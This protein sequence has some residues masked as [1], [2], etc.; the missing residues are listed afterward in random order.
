MVIIKSRPSSRSSDI[1][2]LRLLLGL[3]AA[4]LFVGPLRVHAAPELLFRVT[5]DDLTANA[6]V[7][8]GSPTSALARDLGLTAKEGFNKKSALLLG[9]GEECGY[10]VKDNLNLAA[11]TISFWAKPHNWDDTENRFQK[12]FWVHGFEGGVPFGIYIDSPNSGSAARVVLSYRRQG[13]PGSK[14]YQLNGKADWRSGKWH[15]IDMTWDARHLA[16]YVNG[17]LG[18]RSEITDVTFP[19]FDGKMFRLVPI[20]HSGDGAYH[21]GKDRSLIDDFEIWSGPLSADRILQRYM[22]DI[23]GEIPPPMVVVPRAGTAVTLDGKLD[24]G[25]WASASC[26]PIPIN[27]ATMYPHTRW[28]SASICYDDTNVYV[29]FRSEKNKGPLATAATARDGAVWQDDSFELFLNPDPEQPKQYYQ[30]IVNSAATLFDARHGLGEWNGNVMAKTH[31]TD[32]YWTAEIAISFADLGTTI[33][34]PGDT[35]LG[36]FCRDWCQPKPSAPAYT[37]WAYIEGGFLMHPERYGRLVFSGDTRGVRLTLSPELNV[38][39]LDAAAATGG[40][41]KLDLAIKSGHGTVFQQAPEFDGQA[42]VVERLQG[43]KEGMLSASVTGADETPLLTFAMR[44]MAKEPISVA[45]LP[46]PAGKELGLIVDLTNIDAEWRTAVSAGQATLGAAFTG[47]DADSGSHSFRLAGATGTFSMPFGF[48]TGSYEMTY[49]LTV[50]G[51]ARPLVMVTILEIPPLPWVGSGVGITDDVLT[52]WT[53]MAYHGDSTVSCWGRTYTFDGP[54]LK[55]AINRGRNILA[56]PVG[57]ELT[58]THGT[59]T[60]TTTDARTLRKVPHRAEF[61]G[62]ATFGAARV[63]VDWSAWMEYD[64]LTVA[65]VTLKPEPGGSTVRGLRLRIPMRPDVVRYLRGKRQM[66]SLKTG[67]VAWD[68]KLYEDEFTPFLWVCNEMEGLVWFSESEAGWVVP[69]KTKPIMVQG[70]SDALVQMTLISG[71]V[72]LTQPLSY[73]F[74]FQ[75]TPVKPLAKDRRAWNFGMHRPTSKINARNWLTGYAE[76]DGHWKVVDVDA[77]REFDAKQRAEGVKLLYYGTTSCTPDHNPTFEFYEKLWSSPFPASYGARNEKTGFRP[78]WVPYRL[79]AV[80]PGSPTFQNFMLHYAEEF[81]RECGVPGVY[82]DTDGIMAC[83]NPYHGHRLVDVFGKTCVTYTI[84]AKRRFAKRMA[85][86]VRGFKEERRYWKTH[87]HA[88]LV[89]PVHCWADF[90]LPGEENTHFLRGAKWWYIDT[91]DDVAWRVEYHGSSSGLVHQFLPEFVRGTKDKRDLDGPQP[92]ESL[93]AMCAVT[94]VNTTGGYLN[95]DAIGNFWELRD[96]LDLI[97]AEFTGYWEPA[98]PV[99]AITDKALASAYT[100][101]GGVSVIAIANRLA[102]ADTIE[103]RLDL[104]A[105]KLRAD[106]VKAIDE[107]TGKTLSVAESLLAVPVPGRNYTFVSLR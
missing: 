12:F 99:K 36:N 86:I 51:R 107:R 92:S 95:I 85:A 46:D 70:G 8:K 17:R 72:T 20:F 35:W 7:A 40:P 80:C 81:M 55:T 6:G 24:E 3:A 60:L 84:L 61:A 41:G 101:H 25:A 28:A 57:M 47:P 53:P 63:D 10:E 43:V 75:T 91:L 100:T 68:G 69:G 49:R 74:G 34:E 104:K 79:A 11:G 27:A 73:T 103:V 14:L 82:T 18:Q 29:G 9:D 83:D 16:I 1:R 96:R 4:L 88:K 67:R 54:F 98:C 66:G 65:T 90:W 33:P 31:V 62:T 76:Q 52:P 78:A 22:A 32:D 37:G 26:V 50:P 45:Y 2:P 94:D 105:L 48:E 15:K 64:G 58:T 97:T 42:R 13:A 39:T 87:A 30:F 5:F 59:G 71:D 44:F 56:G 19:A 106:A 77:V 23:G 89:P 21:S 38:G 93:I 102:D